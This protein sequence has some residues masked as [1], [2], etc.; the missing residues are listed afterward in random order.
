M[1]HRQLMI[2]GLRKQHERMN[3]ILERFSETGNQ[4]ILSETG[5]ENEARVIAKNLRRLRKIKQ[6]YWNHIEPIV[7]LD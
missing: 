4:E 6:D 5:I 1:F 7:F 3:G 2:Q